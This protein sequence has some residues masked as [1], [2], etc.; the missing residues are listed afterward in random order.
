MNRVELGFVPMADLDAEQRR[1]VA[2]LLYDAFV[3][4]PESWTSL[5]A[6]EQEVAESLAADRIS[7][8][9]LDDAN[10][11][12][13]WIGAI[14]NYH[15]RVWELHPL[16]VQPDL[17]NRGI[18]RALVDRLEDEVRKRGGLTIY[19]GTD[20]VTNLTSLG[21]V[22]LYPRVLEKLSH[23]EN[24]RRH[25]FGFYQR[26]GFEIVGVVP[27]ANGFGRPDIMMAKRIVKSA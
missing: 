5:D 23:I 16:A 1:A 2:Q 17:Q 15:G 19:L 13:G 7:L 18:G 12:V 3:G 14:S 9:A 22:D 24:L 6:A 4:W 11:V 25:P 27:D 10:Q 8:V 20:D 26:I 21:G